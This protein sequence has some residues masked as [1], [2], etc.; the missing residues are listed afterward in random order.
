[1]PPPIW[2]W[3][4]LGWRHRGEGWHG[5]CRATVFFDIIGFGKACLVQ[6]VYMVIF[7]VLVLIIGVILAMVFGIAMLGMH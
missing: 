2:R 5:E 7:F 3:N 1:M 6:L 4:R